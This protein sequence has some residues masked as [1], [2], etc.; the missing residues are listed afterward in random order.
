[1]CSIPTLGT[2]FPIVV[3]PATVCC[4][5]VSWLYA[6]VVP[7]ILWLCF[8][9]VY[10]GCIL[11]VV[12]TWRGLGCVLWLCLICCKLWLY[13]VVMCYGCIL[14]VLTACCGCALWFCAVVV[15]YL[16]WLYVVVHCGCVQC[17]LLYVLI[18]CCGCTLCLCAV[19]VSYTLWCFAV[20]VS[21]LRTMVV[22]YMLWL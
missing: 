3:A 4:A 19:V 1:M 21:W 22:P 18:V 14:Y 12:M 20:I 10:Y 9:V 6:V 11:Y 8:M 15:L 16:L 7:Y 17:C 2:V 5:C 13:I